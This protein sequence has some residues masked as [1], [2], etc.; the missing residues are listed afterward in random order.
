MLGMA[1]YSRFTIFNKLKIEGSEYLMDLPETNV[2]FVSNHQTYYADVMAL[3]HVFCS[4]KWKFKDTIDYPLYFLMPRVKSYYVAAE[5]TMKD[6]GF[7][8]KLFSYTGAVTVKRS[9][10]AKGHDAQR[11]L[12]TEAPD[13]I[14][15]ALESGWVV[16]FPQGT[17]KPYAP[18]RKGVANLIKTFKPLV[19]PVVINGFRRAFDKKGIFM[20]KRGT[21]LSIR[22]KQPIYFDDSYSID[23]IHQI[24]TK[25][26]EQEPERKP[27]FEHLEK[28][29]DLGGDEN[30]LKINK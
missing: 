26:I 29:E 25:L 18:V 27:N 24:I 30:D 16:N 9:W 12:D 14:R 21:T 23:E 20:K 3:Y 8:P 17:T 13:K 22:F 5:E 15:K 7:L 11:G 4:V 1:T 2:M 28:K 19:V 6:S 10:R